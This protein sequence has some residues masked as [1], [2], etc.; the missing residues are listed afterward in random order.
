[1]AEQTAEGALGGSPSFSL[2]QAERLRGIDELEA[3]ALSED[4]AVEL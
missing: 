4:D 1:M 2:E 3:G